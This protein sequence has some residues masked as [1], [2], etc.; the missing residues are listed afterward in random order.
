MCKQ[1]VLATPIA[2]RQARHGQGH[3][4]DHDAGGLAELSMDELAAQARVS[5]ATLFRLFGR[6]AMVPRLPVKPPC[7][8]RRATTQPP[9]NA[10][11]PTGA[12]TATK[13]P[14]GTP[15]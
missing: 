15:P 13:A 11:R 7:S 10:T 14:A 3:G 2:A 6:R 9:A 4:H 8:R 12:Q 5:H 1:Q